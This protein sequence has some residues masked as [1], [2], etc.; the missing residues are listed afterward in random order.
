MLYQ[1][2][3]TWTETILDN[4]TNTGHHPSVVIDRQGAIHIAYIDDNND[5][6]RY[7][8]N[9]SGSWVFTT[10]GNSTIDLDS[11]GNPRVGR[12]TA[13]VV[14]PITDAVHI[15]ATNY[16][17]SSRGLSYHTNEGGSWVNE[18]ITDM[19]KDEG[20]DP[21]MAMDADGN[22]H[23][24]HYCSTSCNDLRL[25][26]RIDGV[27]QN[28]TV[29]SSGDIGNNPDI[30]IDSQ[31]TIHIV[32]KY[33]SNGGK[34]HLHSGTPGSWTAQTGLSGGNSMWPV[35]E[36]DSNDA[37]HIA[38]HYSWTYKDLMYMT[39]ASGSWST[40]SKV[41]EWGGWGSVMVI[42]AN[43]DIFIPNIH[44]GSNSVSYDDELQLTTVQGYGQGLTARPIYDVSPM[45]PDGLKMNW[46]NGTISGTP[47]EALA[48]TSFTVTVT[49]LGA[50]T[51]G[52]FT[53]FITGEPGLI[54]YTD[55]QATNRTVITT[56]TPTFTNNS[57]S[58]T[59]TSWT[60]S[61]TLPSGLSFG[62]TNGSIWGTPTL[63]QIKTSYTVWANNTAGSSSTTINITV[64]PAAPGDFE[65]IPEDNVL[66]N[67]SYAHLAPSFV[68]ITTGSG[69]TWQVGSSDTNPG[70]NFAFNINGTVYF[71][72]GSNE[73]LWAYSPGNNSTWRISNTVTWVGE[74]MAHV[75][76]DTIYFSGHTGGTGREFYAYTTT[77]NTIWLVSDIRSGSSNS[78]PGQGGSA[79][80]GD[81]LFFKAYSGTNTKW[82]SYNHSNGTLTSKYVYGSSGGVFAEAIG[83][84]LYFRGRLSSSDPAEVLAYSAVNATI[85]MIE[86][87]YTGSASSGSEAGTYLS[88][89]VNDIL[90]FDAWSGVTNDPRSIW[91]YNP[92]NA[93][94]W[95]LQSTDSTRSDGHVTSAST[96]CGQPL[97]VGDVA[98]FCATGGAGAGGYELWAYNT[99]NETT[100]LVTDIHPSGDSH[101]GQHMFEAL[102]DTLYFSAADG[103]TGIELWA[104]DTS[105]HSTWRVADINSGSFHS[106]PGQYMTVVVGDTLYFSA[107]T[108]ATNQELYAYDTSNQSLWLVEDLRAGSQ[109]SFVGENMALVAGN[110]LVFNAKPSG[111]TSYLYGHEPSHINWMTNTG[112][113]VTTWAISNP[114]LPTGLTFSTS[115][116]TI[117][118]TPTQLWSKTAYMVW[119]NNSGGSSVGYLNITVV[120][121]NLSYAN[122]DLTLTKDLV[123][124]DLPLNP[125]T[126]VPGSITTWEI[127]STL[128]A[129]LNFGTTNGTIWG[130]PTVL[131]TTPTS[132]TIWANGTHGTVSATVSITINDQVPTLS[133]APNTL[134]LTKGHQ[135]SDLPLTA[136]LTGPGVIVS[137]ELGGTLPA[138][139]N[140]GTGNGTLWG[141]PTALQTSAT[142]YTIWA[143]NSGGSSS[144]TVTITV[145]DVPPGPFEYDPENNTWTNN[146]D[147][148]L[149]PVFVNRTTGNG[150]TWQ[151][152]DINSGTSGSHSAPGQHMSILVGDTI[153]FDAFEAATGTELWAY[154]TSNQSLW[155]VTDI[156]S[157]SGGSDPGD[158]SSILV[159]D[160][161]YF[162]AID[163]STGHELWA[164][165]TSN[166][167]TWQVANIRSG[168]SHSNPGGNMM[169]VING[170]LYFDA[171][172]GNVGKELWKHDPSTGTTSRVYDINAGGTGSSTGKWLNMVVGDVLY[173]S[174]NDG[175]TGAEL[176]AYNTSNSSDPWRVMDINSG[177]TGSEPGTHMSLLVG[178]TIYFDAGASSG[179]R[180]LWAHDISNQSTWRV[181][182]IHTGSIGSNPGDRMALLVG[183]TIYFDADDGSTGSEL[184]AHDTSN[185][186][187]WR[188]A[189]I[190]SGSPA[191]HPGDSMSILV[192]N[193]LYFSANDGSTGYELWAHDTSNHSTWQVVDVDPSTYGGISSSYPGD[194]MAVPMGDTIYFSAAN[195]WGE[196]LWAHDTSNRS[197]W[198]VADIYS[199]VTG[200]TPGYWMEILVGDTL[201]FSAND[202][203]T[204]HELWAHQPSRID[205]NTNT[206]GPVTSWTI[207]ASLPS[208]VSFGTTNGTIYGTPTELWTQTSYM[209]SAINSGGSSVA[210]LNITVVDQ[211]PNLSYSPDVLY[212]TNNTVSSDLP[213]AP[214]LTGP[215]EIVTWE[216]N[217][218]L[219]T[220]LNLGATNGTI[221]GV[222]TMLLVN[223]TT[224]TI[225]ANNSG[226]ST[227][228]TVTLTIVDQVP[229]LSYTPENLTLTKG[230][231]NTDLPLNATLSGPGDIV[232]WEIHPTL[233]AG[234]QFG[235]GNGTVWGTPTVLQLAPILYTV[236]ANNSG[237]STSATINITILDEV[238][239]PFEYIPEN[240]TWTNNS[241]VDLAPYFVNITSGNGSSWVT[242]AGTFTP[243]SSTD[244]VACLSHV[245]NGT[246]YLAGNDGTSGNTSSNL[247][248]Y[249]LTNS[250][251]WLINGTVD[252]V[253]CTPAGGGMVPVTWH[254]SVSQLHGTTLYFRGGGGTSTAGSL[255]G[256]GLENGTM[257]IESQTVSPV[258]INFII[259]DVLLFSGYTASAGYEL[260]AHNVSNGTS[261]N[262]V[263]IM[264]GTGH[265]LS[266]YG[267]LDA[268]YLL[269]TTVFFVASD[270]TNIQQLWAFNISNNTAWKAVD[271]LSSGSG[272]VPRALVAVDD[273]LYFHAK[274]PVTGSGLHAYNNSNG[275]LWNVLNAGST[276]VSGMDSN[277]AAY[278]L[279]GVVYFSGFNS[280][281]GQF[282]LCAHNPANGTT[283]EIGS[284]RPVTGTSSGPTY[285]D[286][287][288]TLYY[289]TANNQLWAYEPS[290]ASAW[291][292]SELV[293]NGQTFATLGDTVY[294]TGN[295]NASSS[296]YGFWAHSSTNESSWFVDNINQGYTGGS[297]VTGGNA[298]ISSE[299]LLLIRENSAMFAHQPAQVNRQTNTGGVVLNWAINGTL[300]S[301]LSFGANNGTVYGTPT[302]LWPQTAYMVWANNSGGSTVTYL[303]ITV[304]DQL[305]TVTYTPADLTLTNN[306][307]SVDLP[308]EPIIT[309]PGE[310]TS[311]ALV[312]SLPTGLTFETS[313]GTIWGTPTELWPTT[314][315]VVWANNSGGSTAAYLNITVVDQ[316][317]SIAYA[318]AT[319]SLA[320]NTVSSDLPLVPSVSGPGE[321]TSWELNASLPTG[322][323][324]E[325]SNGTIWGTPTQLWP[326]TGYTVWANNSG[327]SSVAYISVTVVDQ[328]PTVT[329]TPQTITLTNNTASGDL[330][331]EATVS[332]P[333][334]IT[335]WFINASLPT[336]LTFET[337]NGT[338]WGTPTQLLP[339]TPYTIWANNSGGSNVAYLNIT[340]IDQVPIVSYSPENI[341]LTNNTG[342]SDLPLNPSISGPGEI[343]SWDINGSLPTGV[344]FGTNNGT[345]WG[346]PSQLW[347]TTEYTVWANNSGGSTTASFN[348]TVVDQVPTLSYSPSDLTLYNNTASSDLPLNATLTG[349]GDIVSWAI[350]PDLPTGLTFESSNG[351]IWG[352]PTQR[353]P[354]TMFTV[355][356]NNSGGTSVVNVNITVLHESP[357]FTY[358]SYNLSL[359]NNTV[360]TPSLTT[361]TG[362]EITSWEV[363]PGMPTGLAF[364]S[365]DGTISGRP[366]QVQDAIMYV[367]WGNNSGGSHAVYVNIT[368]YDPAVS[369]DY[370]PENMTLTRNVAMTDM[371][372]LY[373]GI[374]DDWTIVPDLPTGLTFTDGVIAGTPTVNLTT[375]MFTVWAN[376]TGGSSNHTINLTVL[377]PMV[378][379]DYIPENMTL[380]RG[381]QMS[382]MVPAVSGGM[383]EIWAI[384]PAL[385]NGLL[386]ADG[387]VS[388]TPTVNM[389][390]SMFTVWANTSGGNASHTI[391]I[392]ILEPAGD[393]SYNPNNLTLTRTFAM[394][395]LAPT[396]SGGAVETWSIHPSLP[397]G[398]TFSNGVIAGT[399]TVN[400]TTTMFTVWANNSGGVS[401]A[402]VNITV[403]EPVVTLAYS[404]D[405]LTLM[406]GTSMTPLLPTV[407]GG[408]VEFWA[409]VGV[410]PEGVD[411][412][413]GVFSGTPLVNMTQT[414]YVVY[415][416]TSGGS[417]MA[418]V[419][420]TVLEPPVD[421]SYNPFNITLVRNVTMNPLLP[422]V[423]GGNVSN[424][425]ITPALPLGLAFADGVISGTPEV[426]M[427]TT[428][429]TVWANTSGGATSTTVNITV[430]EPAVDFLYS[431]N[432]LILTRTEAMNATSP[433]FGTDA[434]AETWAIFPALPTGLNFANGTV[435]GTPEVNMTATVFTVYANNSAGSTT[436]FLTITVL[437]PVA[438]VVYL[439]E[440]ITLVRGVD[441]ANIVPML[442]G[443]MVAAWSISPELSEGLVFADGIISGVPLVNS[444]NI[445]YTV[446]AL[447]S[448]GAAVAFLNITVVEP[449][450]VLA[451]NESFLGTR[452]ETLFNATLD[453]TGG[454]VASWQ[455]EPALPKGV[456]LWDG[457]LYGTPTVNMTETTYTV[458]A[459]NS[460]GSANIT[461]TLRVL[462]PMAT[463][464]YAED[465]ITLVSGIS[466]ALIIPTIGGGVPEEWIIEPALP[467]GLQFI[468]GYVIGVPTENLSTTTYT[469]YAN[470]SGGSAMA[471]FTLTVDLPVY[472]ARYPITRVVLDVNE[473]LSPISPIYY[474]GDNQAP[475]WSISP[476]LPAGLLFE[477]GT[478]FGTPTVAANETNHTILVTGEMAPIAFFVNIEVREEVNNTVVSV[479]NT[480][481]VDQ[482]TLPEQEDD[483]DSFDMYWICPPLI[484][485][486][487]MLL[488]AAINNFLTL[489]AKNED[490]END[491]GADDDG[492]E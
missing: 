241:H 466:R 81:V 437:E 71:N 419:N 131:Q 365:A 11:G 297:P 1:W 80:D 82:F 281:S 167:T 435:S 76:E 53:L 423:S 46:R 224:Y 181:V 279:D 196:E 324:F 173:F 60:I 231:E 99:S 388:G 147:V 282:V 242:P 269:G 377:E 162:S 84:T 425:A 175:S 475:L 258:G 215:G 97:V 42:D 190:Y 398:L 361:V 68:N 144:A 210:Y 367:V 44:G 348:L 216:I 101:P 440:N 462:E 179:G 27:W 149:A 474:F 417:T 376:N 479:R 452:G 286:A 214:T 473:T 307:L 406:R 360:M 234:L 183:D 272:S 34:I 31:G 92:A 18:T 310:F 192:G 13:I 370:V 142:V 276:S 250:T 363:E 73:K 431:T 362:G 280:S 490:D 219:P 485:V 441:E 3:G 158:Y 381:I 47:T 29:S 337:S 477:N 72:A 75:V 124:S 244:N 489:T 333:G 375:T 397:L 233:P 338:I 148:H 430:L 189:D 237:G 378:T 227:S 369:L 293:P 354:T 186:S 371:H 352:V 355:W 401:S 488:A 39:N 93:T 312:G 304:I 323:T 113:N 450:A 115:N 89:V 433:M 260:Y 303:N 434:R 464:T 14:H 188:V 277:S 386:F 170:V 157:G 247:Y 161:L 372:P 240:N 481:E 392:T 332:G 56:A 402:T 238:P 152:A 384:H 70:T 6:L 45:L 359:V 225:W 366:T 135:S 472:F 245:Y 343:T 315:Y 74:H 55:I 268:P 36:V 121:A 320:N 329:Y 206:G 266:I 340:V 470:N 33:D 112:G 134:V 211:V 202:G 143:N 185:H 38:Y 150:S 205:D 421:L 222:P 415:A 78:D 209:V 284:P 10:L 346:I 288:R 278:A 90:L 171:H 306:T 253:G 345:L 153:Y 408:S 43:D 351:T 165:N 347:P 301:G 432:N 63:E 336:G 451:F 438:T 426:N 341:T 176:W 287:G 20:H 166:G 25:S 16:E 96:A 270:T 8:T 235:T 487:L 328:L 177:N 111:T 271:L 223:A 19:T 108:E 368:V 41:E 69:T 249:G 213:L 155:R 54:A 141:I 391:N 154:D 448:G 259:G 295:K 64:G 30:A 102:G 322:L 294:L 339:T 98:Y 298:L 484:F 156:R 327:G 4:G 326:T 50:T 309:G 264:S 160:T 396:Y 2:N 83:D 236:W 318:P 32:S 110:K 151:V 385:P 380:V 325:T 23:V 120:D 125:T 164:H 226:G 387:T 455:I 469:V 471:N 130:I 128:P 126:T 403:L 349:P 163:G 422:S 305:P 207:N 139:L 390:R 220:G 37:V 12:G 491:D 66:I 418:W 184:W 251:T 204:G 243:W 483:D 132:Y 35:V 300:P 289:R 389:T 91:A 65:Y 409:V 106:N 456:G 187:T 454:M 313:N 208:G 133:Y 145:N 262:V 28:E 198:R 439:P 195:A 290:N 79:Q 492:G 394:T 67:N 400:L 127:N 275:T 107:K 178:D 174:A 460:G 436:A 229:I 463:I 7:A 48:N 319:L 256:Y 62:T 103:S 105:N 94:A 77:N 283:W 88:I 169:H 382:D 427:T 383:V 405:N 230:V 480:S 199:G 114:N 273:V 265:S 119:A 296:E 447:N 200:G 311:W 445:T 335:S 316:L 274:S 159:D 412:V 344:F 123:S 218:S 314:P 457:W 317:P 122:Y 446:T 239:G 136:V 410:L 59:V 334:E 203:S 146:T 232:T 248:G 95:E 416:N 478:I 331:L 140:F 58:G 197:T 399:P 26:S 15:V 24:A 182:D 40:P 221:W 118:G 261:W 364:A 482:F 193:A 486:V 257:W 358:A 137:W 443:G 254:K 374:V 61:P 217:A 194:Y 9:A 292:A 414:Q 458:W 52:T 350:L 228:A 330:P 267:R 291:Q 424:W 138:G 299:G 357:M 201:Y 442:G 476:A 21:A 467:D 342:S 407:S 373:A 449:V 285:V 109:S 444:T 459:N 404:P 263:D 49:A 22:L 17:N 87:I 86:D 85:W 51:S 429:Y 57:T 321:I 5:K 468:N 255:Y 461:F 411:F 168:S 379:L 356:A 465:D 172:D 117:Y 428:M 302:E 100:W 129:G 116:G 246:L 308:L 453:N 413:N 420:I 252:N 393:L 395:T 180:E 212:L 191:S 353:L 104:Y